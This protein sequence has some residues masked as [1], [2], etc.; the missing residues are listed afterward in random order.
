MNTK[1]KN[2]VIS[3]GIGT[4]KST[5]ARN[6]AQK[7]EWEMIS[8]GEWFR[9]W[10]AEH[11]VPLDQPDEIPPEVDREI[12]FGLQE[13]MESEEG[14]VFES[15]LGG[16]LA[17]D[18]SETFKVLCIASW[19]EMM[20]RA[21]KRDG[22]TLEEEDAYAKKRGDTLY[23]KFKH[24]YGVEDTFDHSF[25]DLVVDTTTLTPEQVLEQVL[26]ALDQQ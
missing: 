24:L 4:G 6:L 23:N 2:I 10:H 26:V 17:R 20:R 16:W 22:K 8:S 19:E 7:L 11:E 12:D 5:L 1:Y 18:L 9:R 15:H 21:A 14:I 25:F 3:G 13:K